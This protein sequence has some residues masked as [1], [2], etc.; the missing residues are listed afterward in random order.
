VFC[1]APPCAAA[2][3]GATW[4]PG[5]TLLSPCGK[6]GQTGV[7]QGNLQ[8]SRLVILC[9]IAVARGCDFIIEQPAG[10]IMFSHPRFQQLLRSMQV[11]QVR[12]F[13]G[14]YGA[15]TNKLTVLW[16]NNRQLLQTFKKGAPPAATE[17]LL[18]KYVDTSGKVCSMRKKPL[19]LSQHYPR[20]FGKKLT[21]NILRVRSTAV[22]RVVSEECFIIPLRQTR[23][24]CCWTRVVQ[25]VA[26]SIGPCV[27]HLRR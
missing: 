15:T 2:G 1:S 3:F 24:V 25:S 8:V 9:M 26:L 13:Q 17:Q 7:D 5:R 14:H 23:L 11:W 4:Q 27:G 16:S 20:E 22:P 19:K 10:S 12:F 18:V 6:Q 21:E